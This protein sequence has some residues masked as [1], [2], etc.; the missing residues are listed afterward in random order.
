VRG[1][2]VSGCAGAYGAFASTAC[3]REVQASGIQHMGCCKTMAGRQAAGA[4]GLGREII[5]QYM[6]EKQRQQF[7]RM[8]YF[9]IRINAYYMT[10]AQIQKKGEKMYGLPAEEVLEMAYENIQAEA[11]HAVKGV[12]EIPKPEQKK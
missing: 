8:R 6:T 3:A 7:N 4:A 2:L 10:P 5:P 12:K 1:V 11:R 9:L